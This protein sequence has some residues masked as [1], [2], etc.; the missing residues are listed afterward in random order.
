MMASSSPLL[1]AFGL[2]LWKP[3]SWVCLPKSPKLRSSGL[4]SW[5]S[6][7]M[8]ATVSLEPAS[9]CR[10]DE[11]VRIVVRGLAPEQPVT[12]RSSLRD[13]KDVLF[14]AHTRYRADAGGELDLARA[15]ALG[16]SY[17][18]IEPMGFLWALEPE[19]PLTRLVK[20]DVQTPFVVELQVLD[21]HEGEGGRLL[22][23]AVHERHFLAPGV[24]REPVRTGRVR[25]TLFLP[26]EPGPFPGIVDIFGIGGGLLEYRASLLAGKGFAVMALAYYNYDD[27]PKGLKNLHLEYF[28]EAVNYLLNH[29][30]V[31]GPGV[32]L[33]GISKGGELCLSMAS[34]LKGITAA[35]I[36]NGSIANVGAALHYQ[37]ETLP[38][39]GINRKR[40]KMTRDG[41]ADILDALNSPLEGPDQ[42]SLI[43]VERSESTFLF[44]V[45]Q[46][47]HNWKS[48]F[49]ANEASK[50]LQ[51]HGPGPFPGIIDL[52]GLGGGLLEYRASLLA[53]HGFATLALAYYDFEDLPKKFNS[54][55]MEYFEEAL[56]SMLQHPQVK[57]PGVG[58]LGSSLGANIC[59]FMASF[60]KNISA[61][62]SINGSGFTGIS[63]FCY[64]EIC[65][66]PLGLDMRRIK[67]AFSGLLDIVDIRN[68]IVGG[69]EHPSM[70]PIEKAEGPI[71]FIVGQ[72]DHN[73]RSELYAQIASD[74]LQAHG[75]KKPQIISYP[76]T[77]HYIEPPYFPMC[78]ASLHTLPKTPVIWGGEPRAHSKAQVD[79]W[80][81]ILTFFRRHL[82]GTRERASPKL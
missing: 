2:G 1:R 23:R 80:K 64:K 11:P 40:I 37:G 14:R 45:G 21:G 43:P 15:P 24:R 77:G 60:L 49:Y 7:R 53:G 10:W 27:L 6:G 73:W 76:G 68:D 72:D 48:E 4:I 58:L 56:C 36:I 57:G 9:C 81:Q 26:P 20:R 44:L 39:L 42:K 69:Y 50:R 52:F 41:F 62:V 74:R 55:N 35:V 66:P 54:T 75:K 29:P 38:P 61:T 82:R 12:L 25:A 19:K 3:R 47:D 30:Q 59:L 33:L 78:P 16:G 51:A 71:F 5:V 32:G 34:F 22:G 67:R 70:F 18:G 65:I 28:E 13:E 17:V 46:D 8:A 31:K 79:A 63:A